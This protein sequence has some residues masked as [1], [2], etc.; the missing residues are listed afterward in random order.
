MAVGKSGIEAFLNEEVTVYLNITRTEEI[1]GTYQSA[2]DH[3]YI[4]SLDSRGAGYTHSLPKSL[5]LFVKGA[6][7]AVAKFSK[8][9][10]ITCNVT[11][12]KTI[13]RVGTIISADENG[14]VLKYI[15][16]MRV[17]KHYFPYGKVESLFTAEYT[18]EGAA[19]AEAR[20]ARMAGSRVGKKPAAGK[21]ALKVVSKPALRPSARRAA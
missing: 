14:F 10:E 4:V 6:A 15:S 5:P 2:T 3:A 18:A 11:T 1:S 21:P 13:K 16:H 12:T 19:A 17:V 7:G 8:G 9:D 20:S